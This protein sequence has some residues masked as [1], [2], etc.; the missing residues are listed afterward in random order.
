MFRLR[1]TTAEPALASVRVATR[2]ARALQ[3]I[4]TGAPS[5]AQTV[6]QDVV[7]TS[8][9]AHS[10]RAGQHG[11]VPHVRGAS[12][13]GMS[14]LAFLRVASV[15]YPALKWGSVDRSLLDPAARSLGLERALSAGDVY[16]RTLEVWAPQSN[17]THAKWDSVGA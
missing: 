13:A 5:G 14:Q 15:E 11:L 2:L 3:S 1:A 12:A 17:H 7:L 4:V 16:G 10:H 9:G 8:Q 6:P